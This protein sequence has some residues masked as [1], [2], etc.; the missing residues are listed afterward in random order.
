MFNLRGWLRQPTTILG[1]GTSGGALCAALAQYFIGS[2]TADM[3]V[4]IVFFCLVHLVMPDNSAAASDA[5]ALAAEFTRAAVK[6]TINMQTIM[7][8]A[9]A[10][11]VDLAGPPAPAATALGSASASGGSIAAAL[12]IVGLFC[13][14]GLAAC[15]VTPAQQQA[16]EAKVTQDAQVG[17]L[18]DGTAQP[19]AA[20]VLSGLVPSAA[21]AVSL[22]TL[23][24]H[25]AVVNF[26]K[27]LGGT[28]TTVPAAAPAAAATPAAA[29]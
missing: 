14:S 7:K 28:T 29:Q 19:I 21:G 11:M 27:T 3:V 24:V 15:D 17:C 20:S 8:D 9:S 13:L 25:P 1:L 6:H 12:G 23:L 5:Q 26:C 18:I 2:E 16:I 10:V 4:G 22:D